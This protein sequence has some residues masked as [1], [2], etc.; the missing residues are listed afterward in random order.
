MEADATFMNPYRVGWEA[1]LRHLH[2]DQ[3]MHADLAAGIRDVQLAE[4]CMRSIRE[5]V[6]VGMEELK[7]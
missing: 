3:P 1:F 2:S 7:V 6:W 5:R 4:A